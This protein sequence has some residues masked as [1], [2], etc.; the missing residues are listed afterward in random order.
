MKTFPRL[1]LPAAALL[2]AANPSCAYD[3]TGGTWLDGDIVMHLQLGQPATPLLDGASDWN[4]VAESA[5]NEWNGQITRCRFT[6]VRASTV[7][8]RNGNRLNNVVFR[9]DAFGTAFDTRTLAVTIGFTNRAT[10]RFTEQDVV[11]NSN[12]NWNS[13]RGG[14][15]S[16][17]REFRRVALH[18][19]GHVLGLDHPDTAVPPQAVVA[20]MNSIVSG[21]ETLMDD[22][23]TGIRTLYGA[24]TGGGTTGTNPPVIVANP[25]S[26]TLQVGDSYTMS[27]TVTGTGPFTYIWGFRPAGS[28]STETFSLADGPSYTIG[29]V[30]PA[31][32][33]T[34]SVLV[35]GPGG[36]VT[37]GSAQLTVTLG[38]TSTETALA[39]L[40]TRGL[41][42]SGS[43][44]LIA[45]IV[46]GGTSPKD[47][48]VRAVGPALTE[49]GVA[50]ALLDPALRIVSAATGQTIAQNDD[51]STAANTSALVSAS[52]RLGAFQFRQGS[53]DAA[54]LTT[55]APGSYTAI[56]SGAG[57]ITGVALVEVYDAD[58]DAA[59]ARTRR[60]V[61]IA[62]RGQIISGDSVLIAGLVVTG[63]GPRTYLI[64]GIGPTLARAP[65][66]VAGA[67]LDP[68]LEIYRGETLLRENDDWDSPSSGMPALREAAQKAGAFP[69]METRDA[70]T[71][72]GLDAA[73]LIT[74]PPGN[75]T[76]KL[77]GFQGATGIGLI[78]IYELP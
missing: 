28:S 61:N 49:F 69:L 56:V 37:S 9:S 44:V 29:S 19:F 12:L 76:A 27:V 72:S 22:D 43:G 67:N 14:L 45:G 75:Y 5:L 18:E 35:R 63:P 70:V 68:F 34:Y 62:T 57:D 24:G 6:M 23:I 3:L 46:I 64:R 33:G 11:F 8:I 2:L 25:Q 26:R 78:E 10:A 36:S 38:P 17:I 58:P 73:M 15:R 48:L 77:S 20:I 53:R 42:G 51:W 66:N 50:G 1:L 74:L 52:T 55:L 47:I 39:N 41:V 65:F 40:S 13:Y 32:A 60:L 59:T 4:V 30:Q 54:L 71:R 7:E 16:G 21:L 31:D